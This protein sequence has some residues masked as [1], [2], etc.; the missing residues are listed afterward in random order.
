MLKHFINREENV[1]QNLIS[2]NTVIDAWANSGDK[3]GPSRAEELMRKMEEWSKSG[4]QDL[5]PNRTYNTVINT[6][7][8]SDEKGSASKAEQLLAEMERQSVKEMNLKPT[9]RTYSWFA[10]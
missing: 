9:F 10:I 5:Q 1:K 4:D 8:K 2:K 7:A 3:R 6:Y